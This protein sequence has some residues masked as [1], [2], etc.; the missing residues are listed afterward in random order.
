MRGNHELIYD[1]QKRIVRIVLVGMWDERPLLAL[2]DEAAQLF[3]ETR[4]QPASGGKLLIDAR[5]FTIQRQDVTEA[6][7]AI[8]EQLATRID[9]I[10]VLPSAKILQR[11]QIKRV[12]GDRSV[13]FFEDEA[14]ANEWLLA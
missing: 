9:R 4:H 1:P 14:A 12:I 3:A 5:G 8:I 13:E 10:A 11:L 2:A 7:E 6:F